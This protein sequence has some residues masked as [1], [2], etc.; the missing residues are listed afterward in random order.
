[1]RE[2]QPTSAGFKEKGAISQGMWD[3]S[4]LCE[5]PAVYSLKELNSANYLKEPET[6]SLE[7][8]E[9]NTAL[10]T[11]ET[12]VTILTYRTGMEQIINMHCFKQLST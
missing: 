5:Q 1:M 11:P 8:P 2:T 12:S 10:L 7:S 3:V 9:R 4:G 6:D